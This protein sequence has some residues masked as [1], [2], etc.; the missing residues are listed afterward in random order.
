MVAELVSLGGTSQAGLST[1]GSYGLGEPDI[2]PLHA[3]PL[4]SL[5]SE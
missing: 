4:I 1:I 2:D 3:P 5:D